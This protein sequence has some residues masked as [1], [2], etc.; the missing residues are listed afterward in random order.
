MTSAIEKWKTRVEAHH[1]QS[2]KVQENSFWESGDFWRPLMANFKVDPFRTDD[3]TLDRLRREVPEGSTLI[4]VGGGAGRFA[5]PLALKCDHVTVVEPADSMVEGLREGMKEAKIENVSIV[6]ELW[7]DAK[8][9][10]ADIVLSAHSIYGVTDAEGFLGKLTDSAV[11]RVLLLAYT[12]QPQTQLAPFWKPIHGE[13]RITLPGLVELINVLW[14][15]DIYPDLDMFAPTSGQVWESRDDAFKQLL[16]RLHV[17][18]G[19]AE[20]DRLKQAVQD[21]LVE[22]PDGFTVRDAKPRRQGLLSWGPE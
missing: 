22:T 15:M 18:P 7:E 5:L 12:E 19:S 8:V 4:D 10:P 13:D 6:N 9:E 2:I 16:N 20:E 14:S 17:S 3:E 11:S 21:L 1:A